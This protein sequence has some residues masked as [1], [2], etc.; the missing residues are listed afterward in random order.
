MSS[1]SKNF[2]VEVKM[3]AGRPKKRVSGGRPTAFAVSCHKILIVLSLQTQKSK[4][5]K[6]SKKKISKKNFPF[7]LVGIIHVT[8]QKN[9]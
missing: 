7:F 9:Q 2:R 3:P 8:H 6:F 1:I 5:K 4:L